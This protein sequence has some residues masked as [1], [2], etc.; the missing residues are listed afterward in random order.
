MAVED[1]AA[2]RE[3]VLSLFRVRPDARLTPKEISAGSGCG[4]IGGLLDDMVEA[5]LLVRAG[6]G[7][8]AL[9][10]AMGLSRGRLRVRAT[11]W[12]TM[13][14]GGERMDIPPGGLGRAVDGDLVLA[15]RTARRSDDQVEGSIVRVLE[16]TR[17]G[18]GG[19]LRRAGNGWLLDPLDPVL[20]RGL[21]VRDT[22]GV[23]T[24]RQG[25]IA[26]GRFEPFGAGNGVVLEEVVGESLSPRVHID[27]LVRDLGLES[28]FSDE[29]A[30]E[31]ARA[32]AARVTTEGREDFRGWPCLTIDPV[33][34]RD[35]DDA[36]SIRRTPS[37]WELGVHIAD[38]ASYV[39]AGS[40]L[41]EAA[42]IRGTSVYLPDRV[43]PMLPEELSC[44]ACS[45]RPGEDR[46][47]R[48]VI[49]RYDGTGRRIDFRVVDSVIRSMARLTYEEA[50]PGMSGEEVGAG[51]VTPLLVDMA[52]LSGLLDRE[53][54][55]RGALD[56][57]SDEFRVRFGPDGWPE[58]FDR[59][60]DD[61]SHRMIENF[62]VEANRAVAEMCGWMQLPALYRVHGE[63]SDEAADRLRGVL[64]DLG[65]P[66]P[67]GRQIRSTDVA[68]I[69]GAAKGGPVYPLAREAVLRSLRKAVY[70]GTDSGHFGLA[71]RNYAHFTSP[72]RRYPDL[73]VHRA[74]AGASEAGG[75][76]P[77]DLEGLADACSEAEQRAE[78]AE[79]A[80]MEMMALLYLERHPAGVFD[81]VVSGTADFGIFVRLSGLPL[82]GLVPS[83][84][85]PPGGA[86]RPGAPVRVEAAEIDTGMRRLTLR[87]VGRGGSD[88]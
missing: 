64:S 62:M 26:W 74:L 38:V 85:L 19:V 20:P 60:P 24:P 83:R 6:K 71:L 49:L 3:A 63:P 57:G 73:V 46:L 4:G 75:D 43:L 86:L 32:A 2:A 59:Q 5:G 35:F 47:T 58:G 37:G 39:R 15:R 50:L 12:G 34:A 7:R 17:P 29:V 53:R 11:G 55:S 65:L 13:S 10:E 45:L 18:A 66:A 9:P 61:V 25:M 81:G 77:E 84:M 31:A 23:E 70:S 44:G 67:S 78:D 54:E 28:G 22:G 36:V 80:S 21:P 76:Q 69:L 16:R 30:G 56:L 79:R 41:D 87:L 48:S 8:L 14:A 72:I 27:T 42:R 82:D 33:D 88:V 68:R 40:L 52:A 51:G 1:P